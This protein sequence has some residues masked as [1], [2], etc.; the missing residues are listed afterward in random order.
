MRKFVVLAAAL[1]ALA[2]PAAA[3]AHTDYR[4]VTLDPAEATFAGTVPPTETL[5]CWAATIVDPGQTKY[6][7][8]GGGGPNKWGLAELV[9]WSHIHALWGDD[10]GVGYSTREFWGNYFSLGS[11]YMVDSAG[12]YFVKFVHKGGAKAA[13]VRKN[14]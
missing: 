3:A 8:A 14:C 9:D 11:R 1:G 4:N 10:G 6:V 13:V 12:V 5:A 2:L 7:K